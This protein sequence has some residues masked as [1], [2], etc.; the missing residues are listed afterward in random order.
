[1][2]R[3]SWAPAE[4]DLSR[5]SAARVYDYYLGGSHNLEVDRRLARE[6]IS[7]WPDLPAIMQANRAFLRRAVRYLGEQ[8]ITQFLDIGSGIPTLGN[9][10][11]VAQEAASDARVIY[12]DIDPVAVAHGQAIL[13]NNPRAASV[14]ADLRRPD[15]VLNHPQVLDLLDFSQPV[16]VLLMAVLHF[17]SDDDNPAGIVA[18]LHRRLTSG[19]YVA[20]SHITE[21]T[22]GRE[23]EEVRRL[24]QHTPTPGR[25]RTPK[26]IEGLLAGLE[27]IE[28][29][30]VQVDDW[31][32]DSEETSR[33]PQAAVMLGGVAR[34]P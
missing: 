27:I 6:A 22:H 8:G 12:V 1:M 32:P 21:S 4:V 13:A 10:H 15:D 7:L 26:Q 14:E 29:G 24:Y 20:I 33:H 23:I 16:A 5:P 9:V 30:V 18:Q 31:Y 17:V 25:P 28:P 19:S 11:E 3:P 34:K 2:S